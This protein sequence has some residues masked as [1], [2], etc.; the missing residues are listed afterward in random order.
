MAAAQTT[1]LDATEQHSDRSS[2]QRNAQREAERACW[3]CRD[4]LLALWF[5]DVNT[6]CCMD[7]T[8]SSGS[9]YGV[10]IHMHTRIE[11]FTRA[12]HQPLWGSV[13]LVLAVHLLI[14]VASLDFTNLCSG[15]SIDR[16]GAARS[17][18]VLG[19]LNHLGCEH[20]AD[21]C[22]SESCMFSHVV[23]ITLH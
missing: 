23:N 12:L 3:C 9:V 4:T 6:W 8:K 20:T 18:Q 10:F 16:T 17:T 2:L 21:A 7:D 22:P 15:I 13:T 14:G 1:L 19:V 11:G 5:A